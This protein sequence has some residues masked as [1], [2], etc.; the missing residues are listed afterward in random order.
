MRKL[1][2]LAIVLLT[3]L[4]LPSCATYTIG[5]GLS[6]IS[7]QEEQTVPLTKYKDIQDKELLAKQEAQRKYEDE[8]KLKENLKEINT[9]IEKKAEVNPYPLDLNKLQLP[10][11]YRPL[12]SKQ[13]LNSDFTAF[14][15]LLLPLGNKTHS[16]ENLTLIYNGIKDIDLQFI[17]ITGNRENQINFAKLAARDAVTLDKGTILFNTELKEATTSS[18]SFLLSDKKALNLSSIS[19]LIDNLSLENLDVESY[20]KLCTELSGKR[21]DSLTAI[22]ENLEEKSLFALSDDEPSTSDWTLFT[23]YEYRKELAWPISDVLSNLG[24]RDTYRVT[25]FSEETDSGI[26]QE[27][28]PITKERLDYLYSKGLME[29]SSTTLAIAGLTNDANP[30]FALIANYIYP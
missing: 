9:A 15:V 7:L 1:N 29:V 11:I 14:Q 12:N 4:I 19:L 2:L 16:T 25:H 6:H 21:I 20:H 23:P 8:Q 5:K 17:F 28:G 3:L 13:V 27:I 26:T 30:T 24:F 10:H 22:L 18:A